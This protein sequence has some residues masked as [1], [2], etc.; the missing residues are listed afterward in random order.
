MCNVDSFIVLAERKMRKWRALIA[1]AAFNYLMAMQSNAQVTDILGQRPEDLLVVCERIVALTQANLDRIE[2]ATGTF[3]IDEELYFPHK[4]TTQQLGWTTNF[5]ADF[6]SERFYSKA[7]LRSVAEMQRDSKETPQLVGFMKE[8][9]IGVITA[10]HFLRVSSVPEGPKS[11]FPSVDGLEDNGGKAGRIAYRDVSGMN[12]IQSPYG[13]YLDARNLLQAEEVR[14]FRFYIDH[15]QALVAGEV[16]TGYTLSMKKVK[17]DGRHLVQIE[18]TNMDSGVAPELRSKIIYL[19]DETVSHHIVRRESW[20]NGK[21]NKEEDWLFKEYETD[22]LFPG[23]YSQVGYNSEHEIPAVKRISTLQSVQFNGPVDESKFGYDALELEYGH[24]LQDN[25]AN[26]MFVMDEK[27]LVP[28]EDF[29]FLRTEAATNF[30]PEV[31]GSISL[32]WWGL[33]SVI[34]LVAI[35]MLLRRKRAAV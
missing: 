18:Q 22:I 32:F 8:V 1:F 7:S 9:D 19:V 34:A 12:P 4:D 5:L 15:L 10:E 20:D 29:K 13:R 6:R 21:I 2:S 23:V 14:I 3:E 27:G 35:V 31:G 28:A 25:I 17:K 11:D 24:R 26:K 16:E 30:N 33:G